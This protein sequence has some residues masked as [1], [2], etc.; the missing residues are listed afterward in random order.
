MKLAEVPLQ[1]VANRPVVE[2]T[3]EGK[4]ARFLLDT[5]ASGLLVTESA[6]QRLGLQYDLQFTG[7]STSLGAHAL[8]RLTTPV[9]LHVG[10]FELKPARFGVV[11]SATDL[12]PQSG[13]DGL[14]GTGVLAAYDVDVDMPGG[15]IVLNEP[16]RCPAGAPPFE[17]PSTTFNV[18]PNPRM[19]FYVPARVDDRDLFLLVDTGANRTYV[20]EARIGLGGSELGGDRTVS[21]RSAGP[22]GLNARLHR[23][24]RFQLGREVRRNV[25]ILVGPLRT[26]GDGLL[27]TDYLRRRRIWLSFAGWTITIQ[28]PGAEQ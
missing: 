9:V 21:V 25:N 27:G 1:I 12:S 11:Q 10:S 5:G 16:R 24:D 4:P 2:V 6:V 28:Q 7:S 15:H 8:S 22:G 20:N 14:L 23:F 19:Y 17:G 13:V 18:P 26:D 3:V